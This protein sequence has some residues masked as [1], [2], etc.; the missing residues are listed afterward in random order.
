MKNNK[1]LYEHIQQIETIEQDRE[2]IVCGYVHDAEDE[3][4][5]FDVIS[6]GV[7]CVDCKLSD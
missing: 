5:T 3:E 4:E 7:I 1:D 2:C 6:E